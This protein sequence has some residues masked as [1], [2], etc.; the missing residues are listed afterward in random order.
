G[1]AYCT[2][3]NRAMAERIP[4]EC[5]LLGFRPEPWR[6]DDIILLSRMVGYLTL[7]QS[8][9]E[10]ERFFI[11]LVQAGVDEERLQEL[12]P[13][14][15]GG[16]DMDLVKKIDLQ[17]RLVAPAS[18]WN[19]A[20]PL[21]MA[22][23]NWAV[24]GKKTASQKPML[25][26]DP[27]LEINRLPNVWY[28]IVLK[29]EDSYAMGATMPGLPAIIV[30]R[31]PH[32]AWSATYT[33]MDGTDSWIEKCKNGNYFREPDKWLPFDER[34]EVIKRK[35]KDVVKVV[36][37][38]NSHGV[39]EGNPHEEGHSITTAWAPGR[40]GAETLNNMVKVLDAKTVE[41][42]MD[43]L[44]RLETSWNFVLADRDGNIGFQMSGLMPIRREG[45]SGFVPL[46]GWEEKNDWQGF[47]QP[48]DLPQCLNPECGYFVT[49]NQDLNEYGKV[50][51]INVGMGPYRSDR[52]GE[53][54]SENDAITREYMY[55][56]HY[57]VYSKQAEA[58]MAVL[59]PL[60]PGTTNGDILKDW[61]FQYTA[62]SKGA[63]LFDLF[64]KELYREVFG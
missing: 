13:G 7:S 54:L 45:V 56:L 23:N 55:Q 53:L 57:D 14:I 64:Y 19:L 6:L 46:Q 34:E 41:E 48:E 62:D 51:P 10:M 1:E 49:S 8:Q 42:G 40:S 38:E 29:T 58:F 9:G 2:G 18:L 5:K 11:E 33:F 15:L 43:A 37:Y 52:I 61:D 16:F 39:L 32:L 17:E 60:L 59:A 27:H 35:K 28:E 24:S 44:G 22:S 47:H 26:N 25:A 63:Y 12:F 21:M 20:A 30:G 36:F 31:N 50:D 3:V 4:W